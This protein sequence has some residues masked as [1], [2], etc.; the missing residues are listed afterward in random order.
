MQNFTV[1]TIGQINSTE[2]NFFI[3]V[4]PGFI[5][6]LKELDGFSHLMVIWWGHGVDTSQMRRVLEVK[7]PYKNAPDIMGV[8]AT[9]SPV[10]PNPVALTAVSIIDIDYD[11]GLI[12]IGYI[13]AEPGTPVVDLKPYTPSLDR[14]ESPQVPK[15]CGHWPKSLEGSAEFDW[16]EEFNY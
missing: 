4:E 11:S 3:R 9:R 6:A 15:W 1:K 10:R 7:K 2:D 14:V 5:P 13:D 8:F 12:Q 16:A